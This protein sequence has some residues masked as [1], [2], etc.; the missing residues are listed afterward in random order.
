M[1]VVMALVVWPLLGI[2]LLLLAIMAVDAAAPNAPFG[3][4]LVLPLLAVL[5]TLALSY[6]GA[7]LDGGS[8][9]AALGSASVTLIGMAVI[10]GVLFVVAVSSIDVGE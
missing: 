5:G 1:R 7:R 2:L 4:Q 8:P 10:A 3:A 6:R 9:A